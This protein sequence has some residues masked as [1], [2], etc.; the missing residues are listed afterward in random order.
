MRK[1]LLSCLLIGLL[2]ISCKGTVPTGDQNIPTGDQDTTTEDFKTYSTK[3]GYLSVTIKDDGILFKVNRPNKY[4]HHHVNLVN[5]STECKDIDLAGDMEEFFYPYVKANNE[6]SI[7]LDFAGELSSAD[8]WAE[9]DYNLTHEVLKIKALGGKGDILFNYDSFDYNYSRNDFIFREYSLEKPQGTENKFIYQIFNQKEDGSFGEFIKSGEV[10][11]NNGKLDFEECSEYLET[12]N[13]ILQIFFNPFDGVMASISGYFPLIKPTFDNEDPSLPGDEE[14]KDSVYTTNDGL[15]SITV[16]QD[17]L[18]IKATKPEEYKHHHVILKNESVDCQS[19]ELAGD[20]E[21]EYFY[22]YVKENNKY[23]LSLYL[24]GNSQDD[25]AETPYNQTREFIEITALGGKGDILVNTGDAT[26][27]YSSKTVN[28]ENFSI[29]TP[30]ELSPFYYY[31]FYSGDWAFKK[32]GQLFVH[33]TVFDISDTS[34]AIDEGKNIIDVMVVPADGAIVGIAT[35]L[36]LYVENQ[37]SHDISSEWSHNSDVHWH[38]ASCGIEEHK[39]SLDYHELSD[40]EII[41]YPTCEETGLKKIKCNVCGF[42]AE[43][44]IPVNNEAHTY[45]TTFEA[46]DVNHWHRADCSHDY[47]I[48][49]NV[50]HSYDEW[51]VTSPAT[52]TIDGSQY[53]RCSVCG[54]E[55]IQSIP[56]IRHSHTINPI[57]SNNEIAHWHEASCGLEGHRNSLDNHSFVDV[58]VIKVPTCTEKGL[59]T[60]KC[61]IC[62]YEKQ[63]ELPIDSSA[64]QYDTSSWINDGNYHWHGTTCGHNITKDK[65]SHSFGSWTTKKSATEDAEGL[66]Q[67]ICSI[68]K[69]VE[70]QTI[71]KKTDTYSTSWS[72][73]ETQ[74]WHEA[75]CGKEE[76][77]S[78]VMNHTFRLI[79]DRASTCTKKGVKTYE[80]TTCFYTK[81]ETLPINSNAHTFNTSEWKFDEKT[82]WHETTCGH[83]IK[84]NESNHTYGAWYIL[85][86]ETCKTTGLR[87]RKCTKCDA[88]Q[89][90]IIASNPDSHVWRSGICSKCGLSAKGQLAIKN[91]M[92][93]NG[94]IVLNGK[95]FDRTSEVIVVPPGVQVYEHFDN[96]DSWS[97][98]ISD[99][100][101]ANLLKGYKGFFDKGEGVTL[102][103]YAISKYEVTRELYEAV[104]QVSLDVGAQSY[105]VKY[106]PVT[107][108]SFVQVA[109]FCNKLSMACGLDCVYYYTINGKEVYDPAE[110]EKAFGT[111]SIAKAEKGSS[112]WQNLSRNTSNEGYRV[113]TD[114][115]WEYAARGA[116]LDSPKWGFAFAGI[117]TQ[118]NKEF[119][120]RDDFINYAKDGDSNLDKVG[121]YEKNSDGR[122]HE[123]GLK[124]PNS[125]GLYDMSGNAS[126]FVYGFKTSND[127]RRDYFYRGGSYLDSPDMCFVS[128]ILGSN[129]TGT[130]YFGSIA[131]NSNPMIGF[132]LARRHYFED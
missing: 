66:K 3:D 76:H 70:S 91:W 5:E 89:T 24:L 123:V 113:P 38:E 115:E 75:S 58:S 36:M 6:Y 1:H 79:T 62:N 52:E 30:E 96:N 107:N 105:N 71:P 67:R 104:M 16:K 18:Y 4:R 126:E 48:K 9:S 19:L 98:Y 11:S 124:E 68:C 27:D 78:D 61:S 93:K 69:Y 22:P 109:M 87:W 44:V 13:L 33:D 14:K 130:L 51:I 85:Q 111:Y 73:N 65:S 47:L 119:R 21:N 100:G 35:G 29:V 129:K 132:R 74:H 32:S 103:P 60:V 112:P 50:S 86:D 56:A 108:I 28:I 34:D 131:M 81:S 121:W 99:G 10:Y 53:R 26:F 42:I 127:G 57:W 101:N 97:S 45:Q 80:C 84:G 39:E 77:R 17:G 49:D 120:Y 122:T 102:N 72:K 40:L 125:L 20:M 55:Q 118:N 31:N 12:Q 116:D 41:K 128:T 110:W 95:E 90:E 7:S 23:S 106:N 54:Y 63:V 59:K 2:F 43:E 64:H 82:H 94:N 92:S 8:E 46:N 114:E 83:A 37:H 88:E 15:L 117:N 25:W